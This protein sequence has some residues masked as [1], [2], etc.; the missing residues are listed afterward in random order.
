MIKERNQRGRPTYRR[1]QVKLV[2][3]KE[4]LQRTNNMIV[5]SFSKKYYPDMPVE[6]VNYSFISR[7][8]YGPIE[9]FT[10]KVKKYGIKVGC[11]HD[12]WHITLIM[13]AWGEAVSMD[14][15]VM[16]FG[17]PNINNMWTQETEKVADMMGEL[18]EEIIEL[19]NE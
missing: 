3:D 12:G 8:D 5:K 1:N 2:F 19:Y 16:V 6:D 10:I 18:Y 11:Y 9:D 4:A 14:I 15:K 13:G 7:T 17:S